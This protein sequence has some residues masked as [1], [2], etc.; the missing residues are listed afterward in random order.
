MTH[1]KDKYHAAA[2]KSTVSESPICVRQ[3][4]ALIVE[5]RPE[6]W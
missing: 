2:G 1:N 5:F 6:R 3:G 4:Q